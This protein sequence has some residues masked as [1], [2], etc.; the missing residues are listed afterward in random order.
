MGR[1]IKF[2]GENTAWGKAAE[3]TVRKEVCGERD[4]FRSQ[5]N[6]SCLQIKQEPVQQKKKTDGDDKKKKKNKNKKK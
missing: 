2:S 3:I 6:L 4:V 5:F 1:D